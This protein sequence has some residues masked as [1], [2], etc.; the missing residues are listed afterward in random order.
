MKG[1]TSI[2]GYQLVKAN[3]LPL[4]ERVKTHPFWGQV[5]WYWYRMDPEE[6]SNI[7]IPIDF[8]KAIQFSDSQIAKKAGH[9]I[10]FFGIAL[11]SLVSMEY[12]YPQPQI[13][14]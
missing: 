4:G 9:L 7:S 5:E 1:P 11:G 6:R 14:L 8:P 12:K 10:N 2:C 13:V 3:S